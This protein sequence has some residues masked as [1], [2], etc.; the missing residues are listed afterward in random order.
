MGDRASLPVDF[1]VNVEHRSKLCL[2]RK[3]KCFFV[4]RI[5]ITNVFAVLQHKIDPNQVAFVSVLSLSGSKREK[6]ANGANEMFFCHPKSCVS[7][8]VPSRF[9]L[10]LSPRFFLFV[11]EPRGFFFLGGSL[12]KRALFPSGA[13]FFF[14]PGI[15]DSCPQVMM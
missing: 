9:L 15:H 1:V 10:F 7:A 8:V 6:G 4:I 5:R 14:D 2:R 3:R 13:G 12:S 11:R